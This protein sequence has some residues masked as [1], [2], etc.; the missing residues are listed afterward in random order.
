MSSVP[1]GGTKQLGVGRA[2][3][4]SWDLGFT[5]CHIWLKCTEYLAAAVGAVPAAAFEYP[6]PS[7]LGSE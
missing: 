7:C 2:A 6:K 5:S 4:K 3:G 1:I